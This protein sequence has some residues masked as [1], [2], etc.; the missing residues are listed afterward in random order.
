MI[1]ENTIRKVY[2]MTRSMRASHHWVY[3]TTR[4]TT[5]CLLIL[6]IETIDVRVRR[7]EENWTVALETHG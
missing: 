3:S 5:T 1:I 2:N 6:S 4:K 7:R